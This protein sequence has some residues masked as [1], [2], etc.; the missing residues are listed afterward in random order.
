MCLQSKWIFPR[1]ATKDIV[2]YKILIKNENEYLK[3]PYQN[4]SIGTIKE[5]PIIMEGGKS[6]SIKQYIKCIKDLYRHSKDIVYSIMTGLKRK[7]EGYIHAY[8][9]LHDA[10]WIAAISKPLYRNY[11]IV[12]CIIPKGTSYHISFD[13]MEICA[14]K[15]IILENII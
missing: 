15:M 10:K 12:K 7:E 2:C 4:F 8:T 14:K 11:I 5:L 6:K 1:K 3:T 9:H 13:G